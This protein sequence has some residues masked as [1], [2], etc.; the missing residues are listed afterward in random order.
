MIAATT[1][2]M[3]IAIVTTSVLE[4]SNANSAMSSDTVNPMPASAPTERMSHQDSPGSSDALVNV[5]T[6]NVATKMPSGLP[7]TNPRATPCAAGS[8]SAALKAAADRR[9]ASR[10]ESEDGN[11]ES[12]RDGSPHVLPFLGERLLVALQRYRGHHQS[13]SDPGDRRVH[14]AR[15][16]RGPSANCQWAHRPPLGE[17]LPRQ[18][19]EHEDAQCRSGK[20]RQ[21]DVRREEDRDDRDCQQVVDN[22]ER[23]QKSTQGRR[24]PAPNNGEHRHRERNVGSRGDRPPRER[25]A[26]LHQVDDH[27]DERGHHHAANGRNGG[28]DGGGRAA[29]LAHN[30]LALEFEADDEEEDGEQAV[31][32]PGLNGQVQVKRLRTERELADRFV[33]ISPPRVGPQ[34]RGQ[35]AEQK[36]DAACA[37]GTQHVRDGALGGVARRPKQEATGHRQTPTEA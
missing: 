30:E 25:P 35:G 36:H 18:Q 33:G 16:H 11:G 9:D 28:N 26:V 37:F 6:R 13:Q 23:Q 10:E 4:S 15:V 31:G 12:R 7:M 27:V 8:C 20:P 34:Q 24:E 19:P 21:R 17:A 32:R 2:A 1:D 3:R 14:A 29:Q 22:G 5:A